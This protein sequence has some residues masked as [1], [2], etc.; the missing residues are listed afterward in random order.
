MSRKRKKNNDFEKSLILLIVFLIGTVLQ[1]TVRLV[2]IIFDLVTFYTSKYRQKSGNSF[3]GTYFNKGNYGEFVLYRKTSRIFG[4]PN[5][6]T[7]IYLDNK[8]TESTE[9]DVLAISNKGI[10]VFEMKNYSGYIYGSESVKYWTQVFNKW[11]KN[12]FFNPLRQNY[13]HVKAVEK[14]NGNTF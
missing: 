4:N 14:W 6:L 12:K 13:A 7:N 2:S 9:I 5:V 3:I 10:Y 8:N 11:S 1:I